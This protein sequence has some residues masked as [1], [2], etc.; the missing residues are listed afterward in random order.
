VSLDLSTLYAPIFCTDAWLAERR[1]L[2][3]PAGLQLDADLL[4]PLCA[5]MRAAWLLRAL[6]LSAGEPAAAAC[7]QALKRLALPAVQAF[8]ADT[9]PAS[10]GFEPE[11]LLMPDSAARHAHSFDFSEAFRTRL[12]FDVQQARLGEAESPYKFGVEMLRVLRPFIR[13]AVDAKAMLPAQRRRFFAQIAPRISQLVV[14]PPLARGRQ[15]LALMQAGLLKVELGPS[16]TLVRDPARGLWRAQSSRFDSTYA[17]CLDHLVQGQAQPPTLSR[18]GDSLLSALYRSG[19]LAAT[20]SG[21]PGD[22]DAPGDVPERLTPRIDGAGHPIDATGLPMPGITLLGVPTEGV[23]YF[24]HY[25][26]S[27]RSRAAAWE[28]IQFSLDLLTGR[29]KARAAA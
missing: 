22:A 28:Q 26:P 6:T 12:A 14:G 8:C 1:A 11:R 18:D 9:L 20:S 21:G 10:A 15:W 5:E 16:P 2:R 27:P 4:A 3:G 24:N 17:T 7:R 13:R 23:R 25:L 29:E 19:L